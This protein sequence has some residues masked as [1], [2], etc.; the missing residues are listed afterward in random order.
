MDA[1][2]LIHSFK[3]L[4]QL[5]QKTLRKN[6]FSGMKAEAYAHPEKVRFGNNAGT[7][8]KQLLNPTEKLLH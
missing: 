1:T 4:I 2:P 7:N 3:R 5:V 6:S 8:V